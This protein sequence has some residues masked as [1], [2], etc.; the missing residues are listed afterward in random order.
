MDKPDA[1]FWS[2]L[3]HDLIDLVTPSVADI[4]SSPAKR[5]VC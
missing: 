5:A 4:F 2:S 1:E 3:L